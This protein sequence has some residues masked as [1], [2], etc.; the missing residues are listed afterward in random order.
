MVKQT[1]RLTVCAGS[2]EIKFHIT[3]SKCH[4]PLKVTHQANDIGENW[5]EI[6]PHVC[7][8]KAKQTCLST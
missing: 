7:K 8:M 5:I 6:E 1:E 3:C 2:S 4:E